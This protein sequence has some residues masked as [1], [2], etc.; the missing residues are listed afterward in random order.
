[1]AATEEAVRTSIGPARWT[2]VRELSGLYHGQN[3]AD[4]A[5]FHPLPFGR[6]RW[7][8]TVRAIIAFEPLA[9]RWV[10]RFPRQSMLVLAARSEPDG[11]LVG[12]GLMRFRRGPDGVLVL[13]TGYL[14]A[15]AF[16]RRGIGRSIK[17][18]ML[19]EGY[20]MG[21]R[22]AES[23]ILR[24]NLASQ[25]LNASLGFRL[26]APSGRTGLPSDGE[27]VEA[28]LDMDQGPPTDQGRGP[29]TAPQVTRTTV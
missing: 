29:E 22:R 9:R 18:A 5:S 7:N 17:Q 8:A 11:T 13:D 10:H 12:L 19:A 6:F 27:Y 28:R 20:Q 1:V 2:D 24:E 15:P 16:R 14:V 3:A 25:R 4:R 21:A 23:L 26:V